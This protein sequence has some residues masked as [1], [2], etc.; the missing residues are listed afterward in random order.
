MVDAT[1]HYLS[2][3]LDPT[4]SFGYGLRRRS[5]M[6]VSSVDRFIQHEPPHAIDVIDFG[7]ADGAML[8]ALK[9]HIGSRFRSGTGLDVFRAG[10][11]VGNDCSPAVSFAAV[12]LFRQYPYPVS[13]ASHDIAIVSAF[14]KH[15]PEPGRFLGE[16]ARILR[17]GGIAVL[18]DPRPVVVK[19]ASLFGRFNPDYNPSLWTRNS[20]KE[21]LLAESVA[22][23]D[24]AHFE[25]FWT[26]PNY[27]TYSLGVER[28]LPRWL[29]SL[30]S[31]H[32][33]L[34]LRRI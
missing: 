13:D 6:L 1:R 17:Q 27:A 30:C 33:C 24:I 7:C 15:H 22:G 5:E 11:P 34:I 3:R 14:L 10:L 21:L 9:A 20:V 19:L 31:M 16:V 25:R 29:N 18:L 8:Y 12:D 26:A 2:A 4:S 28:Y 23:F 32:Q